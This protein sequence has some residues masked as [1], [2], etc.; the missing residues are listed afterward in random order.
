MP[1]GERMRLEL[2]LERGTKDAGL[3]AGG[4]RGAVDFDDAVEMPQVERDRRPARGALDR[5]LDAADDAAA[6]A[7]RDQRGLRAARPIGD[8]GDLCLV[9][10]IGDDIGRVVVLT[11]EPARII[12]KRLAVGMGDPVVRFA[13][14]VRRQGRRRRDP[15]RP[16]L[17]L[18]QRRR[19]ALVEPVDAEQP[20]VAVE[21]GGLLLGRQPL[22]FT[23]PAEMFEPPFRHRALPGCEPLPHPCKSSAFLLSE[24]IRPSMPPVRRMFANSDRR[25]ASSLIE[26]E[27]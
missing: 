15:R 26:P 18:G 10:R 19:A 14:A 22:A 3:D 6:G 20:A 11:G 25:V 7:E 12:R 17:D 23:P 5:R 13:R 8:R 1:Q 27:R 21:R 9:A 16:Q 24:A 2:R 4:A